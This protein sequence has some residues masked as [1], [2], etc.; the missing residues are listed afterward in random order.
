V[1]RQATP[2]DIRELRKAQIIH[3]QQILFKRGIRGR[4]GRHVPRD[5]GPALVIKDMQRPAIRGADDRDDMVLHGVN[6]TPNGS[7][8]PLPVQLPVQPPAQPVR[9]DPEPVLD[10][11]VAVL[12]L[13]V[14]RGPILHGQY[15]QQLPCLLQHGLQCHLFGHLLLRHR[16]GHYCRLQHAGAGGCALVGLAAGL[17]D[18]V[19]DVWGSAVHGD[20]ASAVQQRA[21]ANNRQCPVGQDPGHQHGQRDPMGHPA[22]PARLPRLHPHLVREPVGLD[23]HL[24]AGRG[25]AALAASGC[26][27]CPS[28][29]HH[30]GHH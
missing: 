15:Q 3:K 12:L 6:L 22:Q 10:S 20:P 9:A 14:Q 29:A 21:I 16:G 5:R 28:L 18:Q 13:P 2:P 4:A 26:Q 19:L 1:H 27:C 8:Q 11:R 30:M 7:T 24:H 17:F 23:G 25:G